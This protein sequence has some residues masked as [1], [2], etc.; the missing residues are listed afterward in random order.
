MCGKGVTVHNGAVSGQLWASSV[1][2][3]WVTCSEGRFILAHNSG[4]WE[5]QEH[6]AG[7]CWLLGRAS[8]YFNS[9]QKA[10]EGTYR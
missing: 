7:T 4:G 5:V 1:F 10:E 8:C 2:R 6:G 3:G 9:W